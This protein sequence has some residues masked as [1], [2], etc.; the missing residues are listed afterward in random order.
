VAGRHRA[1]TVGDV[2]RFG[3]RVLVLQSNGA[4]VAGVSPHDS[5]Q[6]TI[7][8]GDFSKCEVLATSLDAY[9][10]IEGEDSHE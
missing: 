7:V 3:D 6:P 2:I 8:I 10:L 4:S 9:R 1:P 5:W